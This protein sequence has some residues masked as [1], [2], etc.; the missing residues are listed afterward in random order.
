MGKQILLTV[1]AISL[2]AACS[3]LKQVRTMPLD[4]N[5]VETYNAKVS[6]A[7]TVPVEQ[8]VKNPKQTEMPLNESDYQPKTDLKYGEPRVILAPSIGYY[9]GRHRYYW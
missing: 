8:R 6:S 3:E 7:N 1:A 4:T 5:T 2:L 9:Y